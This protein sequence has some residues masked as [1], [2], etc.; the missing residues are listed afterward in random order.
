MLKRRHADRLDWQRVTKRR[1]TVK[2]FNAPPFQGLVTLLCIDA[3]TEPL[4]IT[5]DVQNFCIADARY[6]WLQ[7]FP[8]GTNYTVTTMFDDRGQVVQWYLD[9]VRQHGVD[10]RGVPWFDDLYLDI[11]VTPKRMTAVLD[12]D[13]LDD[14]LERGIIDLSEHQLAWNEVKRI[15]NEIEK[16]RFPLLDLSYAHRENLLK[17]MSH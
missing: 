13:E 3:V 9:I 14:A 1:F 4:Y 12:E 16:G 7:H 8:R 10:E 6:S 5:T 11:I 15:C 2:A 17:E